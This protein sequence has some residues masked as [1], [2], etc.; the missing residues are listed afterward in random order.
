M[1][2]LTSQKFKKYLETF[3]NSLCLDNYGEV[4]IINLNEELENNFFTNIKNNSFLGLINVFKSRLER[5]NCLGLNLPMPSTTNTDTTERSVNPSFIAPFQEFECNQLNLDT[6]ISYAKLDA[7]TQL[8]GVEFN[9]ALD[10]YLE[11]Q[12]LTA[13]LIAGWNGKQKSGTSDPTTHKLGEDTAKGWLQRIRENA[14]DKVIAE[15]QS[16]TSKKALIKTALAKIEEPFK[17]KG[18]LV[19]I[20]GRDIFSDEDLAITSQDLTDNNQ[21]MIAQKT[22]GGLKAIYCPYFPANAL[23]IT[24]LDNI[25]LYVQTGTIRKFLEQNPAKDRLE[26]YNSMSVDFIIEDYRAVA[27]I[28]NATINE[29][30]E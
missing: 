27:L 7:F 15:E 19:A 25:S 18:N 5:G 13:L 20:C 3:S 1:E 22:I 16:Y 2:L 17:S 30:K 21:M 9:Q 28:E 24:S 29:N 14:Q 4:K 23:L 8:E 11:Q 10:A 12:H 6:Y 26:I